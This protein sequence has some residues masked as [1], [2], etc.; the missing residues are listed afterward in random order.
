MAD[1]LLLHNIKAC[2]L[3]PM[4]SME[5]PAESRILAGSRQYCTLERTVKIDTASER[6]ESEEM[7][8]PSTIPVV[9]SH[10]RVYYVQ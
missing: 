8:R 2:I 4:L 7:V 10:V 3:F 9:A 6:K 1:T 5:L